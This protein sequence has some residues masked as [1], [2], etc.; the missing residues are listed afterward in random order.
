VSY[1]THSSSTMSL[2]D[3]PSLSIMRKSLAMFPRRMMLKIVL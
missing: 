2:R 3:L 1:R